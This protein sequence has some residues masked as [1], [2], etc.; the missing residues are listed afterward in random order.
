[1]SDISLRLSVVSPA[2]ALELFEFE[3]RNRFF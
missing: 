1:M 2:N 3:M